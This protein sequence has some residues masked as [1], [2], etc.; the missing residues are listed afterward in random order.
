MRFFNFLIFIFFILLIGKG[1]ASISYKVEYIGV[2]N[3]VALKTIKSSTNLST[4]KKTPPESISALR[5]RAES[6]V[7]EIIKILHA[8]GYYEASVQIKI[9]ETLPHTVVLVYVHSGPVYSVASFTYSL[10]EESQEVD[11]DLE[12][13]KKLVCPDLSSALLGVRIGSPIL[14]EEV[15][16]AELNTLQKLSICGHP[17]AFIDN[18]TIVADGD[19]KTVA[20]HLDINEGPPVRF[21]DFTLEGNPHIR[22]LYVEQKLEWKKGEPYS[23]AKVEETQ[24]ALMDSGLFSSVAISHLE[25][26]MPDG[27]LPMHIEV[28]ESKHRSIYG[29]VSYQ[30]YYGP[31][32][33]AG[34]EHRNIARMG[35]RLSI[36]GDL[37]KRS[38][39]GVATYLIPNFCRIG[40]DY[41]WEAHATHLNIHPYSAQSYSLTN[42]FEK[43]FNK[44]ARV[45]FGLQGEKLYVQSSVLNGEYWLVEVPIFYGY[46]GSNNLLNPTQGFNVEYRAIPSMSVSWR[47]KGYIVNKFALGCF[48]PL[49]PSHYLVIAQKI[50]GG[51]F[52]SGDV[53]TVPVPKRFFGGSEEDLRGYTYY[54]VSPLNS[55]RQAIGGISALYYTLETR[56]RFSQ[57]FGVVPFLDMGNVSDNKFLTVRGKWRKS[58]GLGLR[59]YSFMGPF[60]LDI[61]FPLNPRKGIDKRYRVLVSIGQSF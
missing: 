29:G 5:Y 23:S 1:F 33:T 46:N 57:T 37:T 52:F 22:R 14:A 51:Y 11:L 47:K 53:N 15:I 38:H 50:S 31:G 17:L 48:L 43:R 18:Q 25:A 59:Y 6:D 27:Q 44:K 7:E 21:G 54:S 55:S 49:I 61:G 16:N 36:Q 60:R 56:I 12:D 20:I 24:K 4:L 2:E 30:T 45:A 3:P 39:S 35:Q 41:V 34:W 9:E 10:S 58:L 19:T 13:S 28:A 8:H 26:P 42:R 32:V 40:Q